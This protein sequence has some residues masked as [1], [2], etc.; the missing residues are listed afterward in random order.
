[1]NFFSVDISQKRE[2]ERKCVYLGTAHCE[3]IMLLFMGLQF[4]T[5]IKS[6]GLSSA[7]NTFKK[8]IKIGTWPLYSMDLFFNLV[9]DFVI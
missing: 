4:L 5:V 8:E 3:I 2:A 9:L 7:T 6:N 1:M